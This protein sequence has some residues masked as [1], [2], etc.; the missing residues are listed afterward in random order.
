MKK[1]A[2]IGGG[3]IGSTMAYILATKELGNV[4]ILDKMRARA[5]GKALDIEQSLPIMKKNISL[6][7]TDSYSDIKNSEVV[8]ITAGVSRTP[9]MSRKDLLNVNTIIVKN[10]AKKVK[11][12]APSAF[13]II[14]TN[15][16]DAMVYVFYKY[17]GF[18]RN[19]VV[20]MSGILDSGRFNLFLARELK[21]S[22][23]DI[24]SLVLGGHDNTM[25]PLIRLSSVN[26]VPLVDLINQGFISR[27]KI[28]QIITRTRNAGTE[29]IQLLKSSSSFYAPATAAI[30]IAESYLN[31]DNRLFTGS[32]YLNGEYNIKDLCIGVPL[33]V[34]SDGIKKIIEVKLDDEEKSIFSR[35]VEAINSLI[36][37]IKKY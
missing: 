19:K 21:V 33:I 7:G 37:V 18:C 8:I 10:I 3:N 24:A 26:G 12:Y 14:I 32:V 20:G 17:S 6:T 22:T 36:S 1:I 27:N 5:E 13:V 34:G 30:K 4:V 29:I 23:K 9:E 35:S 28:E 15:P 11:E 2:L 25:L 31:N 16:L